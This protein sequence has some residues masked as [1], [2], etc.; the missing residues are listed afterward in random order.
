MR[1]DALLATSF[2]A[3]ECGDC[4]KD[5]KNELGVEISRSNGKLYQ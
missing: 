3:G 4:E 1:L 2:C 5:L